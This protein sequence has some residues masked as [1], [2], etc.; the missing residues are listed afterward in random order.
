MLSLI[1]FASN[2]GTA[3]LNA[4]R[5][6]LR[7]DM[8]TAAF[9]LLHAMSFLPPSSRVITYDCLLIVSLMPLRFRHAITLLFADA[10]RY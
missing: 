2:N 9:F 5:C 1:I 6:W 3:R 7:H 8:I 4:T 10:I